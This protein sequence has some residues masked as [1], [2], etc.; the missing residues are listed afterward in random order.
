MYRDIINSDYKK[1][2]SGSEFGFVSIFSIL[3]LL[4]VLFLMFFATQYS[5][6]VVQNLRYARITTSIIQNQKSAPN[7]KAAYAIGASIA[8]INKISGTEMRPGQQDLIQSDGSKLLLTMLFDTTVRPNKSTVK[9]QATQNFMSGIM[10]RLLPQEHF[11]EL[12]GSNEPVTVY[13]EFDVSFSMVGPF[14]TRG[15]ID[16]LLQKFG[17]PLDPNR[18]EPDDSP[19]LDPF[20]PM[21]TGGPAVSPS[22]EQIKLGYKY[23]S[24][25]PYYFSGLRAKPRD[26]ADYQ[27]PR[28]SFV[29]A[30][31]L[32]PT[33]PRVLVCD[34]RGLNNLRQPANK[35]NEPGFRTTITL[36]DGESLKVGPQDQCVLPWNV[37]DWL[38]EK[39]EGNACVMANVPGYGEIVGASCTTQL[40]ALRDGYS[41]FWLSYKSILESYT[42]QV[43]K[44]ARQVLGVFAAGTQAGAARV[45][46][47]H[48][49]GNTI[50]WNG[51]LPENQNFGIY[52]KPIDLRTISFQSFGNFLPTNLNYRIGILRRLKMLLLYPYDSAD[53]MIRDEYAFFAP[54]YEDRITIM[55]GISSLEALAVPELAPYRLGGYNSYEL[56][57]AVSPYSRGAGTFFTWRPS[58]W[59]HFRAAE[60]K[61]YLPYPRPN[62][63]PS[64]TAHISWNYGM[65]QYRD[66]DSQGIP[67]GGDFHPAS[68]T[69]QNYALP[70]FKALEP[71]RGGTDIFSAVKDV[72]DLREAEVLQH[73]G[74]N[75]PKGIMVLVS[76]GFPQRE[77]SPS[78]LAAIN[79]AAQCANVPFD[80][81]I[82]AIKEQLLRFESTGNTVVIVLH[83]LHAGV[84]NDASVPN[85]N[86]KINEFAALFQPTSSLDV[87]PNP[88][89]RHYIKL[90]GL[91]ASEIEPKMQQALQMIYQHIDSFPIYGD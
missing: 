39:N 34:S 57:D 8:R 64:D 6:N 3:T 30:E 86:Q 24:R 29:G 14:S 16:G 75:P 84:Y 91:T 4:S 71:S 66:V 12:S 32:G 79:P 43:D 65:P 77:C 45:G 7:E 90:D 74:R 40:G 78:G 50:L 31:Q 44:V 56:I 73:P 21:F 47:D 72:A 46:S 26:A 22:A 83:V 33:E 11:V 76:D 25:L 62:A 27:H 35:V 5:H 37:S 49:R 70:Y 38:F 36:P 80:A 19:L 67:T 15:M 53:P 18:H 54:E 42:L 87:N 81:D 58:E 88:N 41:D 89:G 63:L 61:G 17:I 48:Y 52:E 59:Q 82:A 60:S 51:I 28:D 85:I 55:S 20:S 68:E 2:R 9:L 10:G 1:V 23:M 69:Q 13:N